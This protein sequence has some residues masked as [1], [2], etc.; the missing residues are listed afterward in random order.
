MCRREGT[1]K[2]A[3]LA[4]GLAMLVHLAAGIVPTCLAQCECGGGCD[5]SCPAPEPI[6]EYDGHSL[7]WHDP[8]GGGYR[9]R[10]HMCYYHNASPPTWYGSAEFV[11]LYRDQNGTQPFQAIAFAETDAAGVITS[12]SRQ[13][14]LGTGDFDND[15]EPGVRAVLGRALGDWYR[16]E[17]AY[18]GSYS[19]ADTAAVWYDETV[20]PIPPPDGNL[21]SPFSNFGNN[22]EGQGLDTLAVADFRPVRGL[23]NNDFVAIGFSSRMNSGELN[24]RRRVRI[25]RDRHVRGEASC[26][27]GLRY[28]NIEETFGYYSE[29]IATANVVDVRTNNDMF[30]VQIGALSQFLVVDRGWI[31]VEIKGALFLNQAS[32]RIDAI[33]PAAQIDSVTSAQ[34]DRASFMGDLSVNFNYQFAPSWTFRVGYNAIWLTGV[35][36]A[37][38]NMDI[39][40]N[41]LVRGPT[42]LNHSGEVCYHGPTIGL[43]WTR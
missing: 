31:D 17:F 8:C 23:D 18:L 33:L 35:A 26:L 13:A 15:F 3:V 39:H 42:A 5:G 25:A 43:V 11:P 22:G 10:D 40:V 34:E 38:E 24:L 30:G 41:E 36:L 1:L 21:L 7:F 19:W 16:L 9:D 27:V 12:Y 29:S 20:N 6:L 14:V 2:R 4:I 32:N 37:S 28:M